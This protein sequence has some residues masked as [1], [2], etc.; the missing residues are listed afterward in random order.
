M[1]PTDMFD[2]ASALI[3]TTQQLI[4]AGVLA[5]QLRAEVS[6]GRLLRVR[7]GHY[8]LP[9]ADPGA[10]EAVRIGGLLTCSSAAGRLGIWVEDQPFTHLAMR[11]GASRM[12]SPRDR[13]AALS[14]DN[15]DGCE[16]HWW[17]FDADASSLHS[18][19]LLDALAAIIRCQPRRIAVAALDS[20]LFEKKIGTAELRQIFANLPSRYAS[21]FGDVDGR[22][23]SGIESIVR[24]LVRDFGLRCEIQ[25][26]FRGIGVVDLVVEGC[27]VIE[28]DGRGNH[29]G[30]A[31]QRRDYDRDLALAALGFG[32]VRCD[33]REVM[34]HPDRVLAA[35][36]GALRSHRR[37]RG[38]GSARA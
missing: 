23:M 10:L 20:A 4:G 33:Y 29:D 30:V 28:T 18:V 17:P 22:S 8:S 26:R 24:L 34:H 11:Q 7:R 1:E 19:G 37:F 38:T 36:L 12:R 3:A 27:V 16:L 14:A 32:V 9:S 5:R 25:V 35:I 13:F 6:S 31:N 15:R 21:I 2:D